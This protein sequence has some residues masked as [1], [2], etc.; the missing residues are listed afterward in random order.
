MYFSLFHNWCCLWAGR[1]AKERY[2]IH[3]MAHFRVKSTGHGF[4][5][6][7]GLLSLSWRAEDGGPWDLMGKV[8]YG[9]LWYMPQP[10]LVSMWLLSSLPLTMTRFVGFGTV[11]GWSRP[12]IDVRAGSSHQQFPISAKH[13][14]SLTSKHGNAFP[15]PS[16]L[17]SQEVWEREESICSYKGQPADP[18]WISIWCTLGTPHVFRVAGDG[19]QG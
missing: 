16:S 2:T 13:W 10:T 5:T 18:S 4:L 15:C 17:G 7:S 1:K 8:L 3:T 11:T 12:F 19:T 14:F 9:Q 6:K